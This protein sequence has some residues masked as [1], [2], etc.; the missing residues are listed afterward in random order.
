MTKESVL[1]LLKTLDVVFD[2]DEI[3]H[4]VQTLNMNDVWGWGVSWCEY[5]PDDELPRVGYL[6]SNYG[7]CGALYWTS[8][9]HN[10]MRSEFEDIN[11]FV[12]FVRQEE[13]VKMEWPDSSQRAYKKHSYNL[14]AV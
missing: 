2:A 1:A 11:R 13:R 4:Y 6:L 5:I 3:E 14:G 10:Q 8:E 7:W 9:R 12:E